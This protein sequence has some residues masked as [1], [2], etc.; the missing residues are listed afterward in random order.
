MKKLCDGCRALSTY[1]SGACDLRH[2]VIIR[3]FW[4]HRIYIPG[5]EC[6][7]PKTVQKY[8][9]LINAMNQRDKQDDALTE[10]MQ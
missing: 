3:G 8:L 5:K 9:E 1:P 10:L 2:E 4:P 6:E 7:K